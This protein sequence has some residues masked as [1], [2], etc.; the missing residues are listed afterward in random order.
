MFQKRQTR[1]DYL[2]LFSELPHNYSET[3]PDLPPPLPPHAPELLVARWVSHD[4]RCEDWP[5]RAA[6]LLEAGYDTP[7]LRMLAGEIR[8]ASAADVEPLV[9]RVFRELGVS[10]PISERDAR[11]LTAR[12]LAREALSGRRNVWSVARELRFLA[13]LEGWQDAL[14]NGVDECL[15]SIDRDP[16]WRPT[17]EQLNSD[18]IELLAQIAR[19]PATAAD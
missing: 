6:D 13:T 10:Y 4:L 11:R 14:L 19:R 5:N 8:V 18:L 3:F 7:T 17:V 2:K 16:E 9:A 1:E 15:E 12:E